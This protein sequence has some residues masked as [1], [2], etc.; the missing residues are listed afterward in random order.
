MPKVTSGNPPA[1]LKELIFDDQ[2]DADQLDETRWV[3]HYLP[4]WTTPDRSAPRYDVTGDGILLKI[5]ADQDEWLHEEGAL[6][7]AGFQSGAWSESY[8]SPRG[9]HRYRPGLTV[10]S[11]HP[12]QRLF[13]TSDGRVEAT[14]RA[15]IDPTTMLAFWLVGFEEADDEQSGE[16]CVIE[17]FGD[18]IGTES[19]ILS[20]G[21]KAHHDPALHDDMVRVPVPIDATD[22]H[23]YA[24][25]WLP[26]EIVFFV[27][28]IEIHRVPQSI[29]YPM[30]LMV[31]LAEFPTDADRDPARY[32]KVGGARSVRAFA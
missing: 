1:R 29:D 6:R 2:F 25:E 26:S 17:L 27:D 20:V 19:S 9:Q 31:G 3:P 28:D 22:W 12:V 32:P 18:A 10:R 8:G 30:Q 4:H 5:E 13:T 15:S 23:T 7:A 14:L 11:P 16:I 21:V 24:A